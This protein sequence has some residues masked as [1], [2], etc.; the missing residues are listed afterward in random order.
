LKRRRTTSG[1]T[2][3]TADRLGLEMSIAGSPGW[4]ESG[5]PWVKPE[6][7][8][9][10]LVWSETGVT[11][12]KRFHAPLPSPPAIA[13]RYQDQPL[14]A[15]ITDDTGAAAPDF[16]RDVAV[17][18]FAVPAVEVAPLQVAVSSSAGPID[19]ALL[20]DGHLLKDVSLPFPKDGTP[21]WLRWDLGRPRAI[22]ALTLA[23]ADR[24]AK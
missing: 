6:Q 7:A 21:A 8:M 15:G 19:A 10:K 16:Y 22:R 4:S 14:G 1:N 23:Q 2:V 24:A 9:K 3:P 12:A 18:A 5:S 13:G 20:S 11:G 17:I